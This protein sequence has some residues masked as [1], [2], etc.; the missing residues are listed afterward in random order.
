[1]GGA[2]RLSHSGLC[3]TPADAGTMLFFSVSGKQPICR[4]S[5][6]LL[7]FPAETS[8]TSAP[9][10]TH[11]R[12]GKH[13]LTSDR[14]P[15]TAPSAGHTGVCFNYR[16]SG[17]FAFSSDVYVAQLTIYTLPGT[18]NFRGTLKCFKGT[19]KYCKLR[20]L[21]VCPI[22][23]PPSSVVWGKSHSLSETQSHQ[24]YGGALILISCDHC[25]RVERHL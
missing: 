13:T 18:P 2:Q 3:E 23:L 9:A 12:N 14:C 20:H 21:R 22:Q 11:I 5:W 25:E 10:T 4:S 8:G 24:Q 6:C 16:T 15:H 17:G 1:M 19:L 7:P